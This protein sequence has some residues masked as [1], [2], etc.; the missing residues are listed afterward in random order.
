MQR[1]NK[2]RILKLS[3]S[4]ISIAI[5]FFI[6]KYVKSNIDALQNFKFQI[7]YLYLSVSFFILSAFILNQSF[8]WYYLTFQNNCNINLPTSIITRIYSEF[9]KYVPGKIV[10]YAMLFFKY[11]NEGKSKMLV[12]FCM[13]FELLS[14]ILAATLIF[15]FSIILT[16]RHEFQ[17]YKILIITLLLAFFILIHPKILNYFIAIFLK[18]L[19]QEEVKLNISYFQLLKIISLYVANFMIFGISFFLFINSIYD[20]SFSYFLFLT[21]TTAAAGLIGLFAI[22]VPAGLGVRE[23][24]MVFTLS[25]IIPPA[26]AGII[27]LTSR[28][29]LTLGEIFIFGLIFIFSKLNSI[30]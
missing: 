12:S 15:L 17:I 28:I 3:K 26:F 10:G 1:D 20:V 8:L 16:E 27:A 2:N 9:G 29:W 7:N 21:G 24:V 5:I 6:I 13:F 23:G 18:I 25:F 4:I 22:F 14:T 19:K 30:K 11:S